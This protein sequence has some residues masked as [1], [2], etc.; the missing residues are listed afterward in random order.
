MTRAVPPRLGAYRISVDGRDEL[1]VAAPIA[2]ELDLRPRAAAQAAGTSALGDRHA[3]VD[4]SWAIALVLLGLLTAEITLR[5][6]T[7]TRPQAA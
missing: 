6:W 3:S 2:R 4:I 5:V 7:K 1:R